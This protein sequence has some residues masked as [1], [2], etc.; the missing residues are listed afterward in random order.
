MKIKTLI[1]VLT[2]ADENLFPDALELLNRTQG[3]DL[4]APEYMAKKTSS[5]N[6]SVLGAFIEEELVAIA[7]AEFI[8]NFDWYLPFD[9]EINKYNG[10]W[11]GSFST[12][13][14]KENLQGLGIGQELSHKRLEFLKTDRKSVV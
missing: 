6:V 1:R 4:F 12:L 5:S 14:V 11:A 9:P 3:R 13:C 10:T 7:V 2:T 8:D